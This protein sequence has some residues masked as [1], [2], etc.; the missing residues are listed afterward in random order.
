M[1]CPHPQRWLTLTF[2]VIKSL[3]V[4]NPAFHLNT[5]TSILNGREGVASK[6]LLHS[7]QPLFATLSYYMGN[8]S[9]YTNFA[10][11]L[12][13]SDMTL[14]PSSYLLFVNFSAIICFF[15]LII[16]LLYKTCFCNFVSTRNFA[17]TLTMSDMILF[18]S[19]YLLFANFSAIIC[20]YLLIRNF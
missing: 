2:T 11:T 10:W 12:T 18:P 5:F 6:I 4:S 13:M 15:L 19:S 9:L 8:P 1:P 16:N 7:I 14:F 20:F 17:W 3:V